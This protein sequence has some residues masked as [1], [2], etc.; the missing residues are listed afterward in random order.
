VATITGTSVSQ[1]AD[2][3]LSEGMD[4]PVPVLQAQD[5]SYVGTVM[6]GS[7]NTNSMIAFDGGG[8]IRWMVPKY[9]P[10]MALDDGGVIA[11]FTADESTDPYGP[12]PLVKFD[13]DGNAVEALEGLTQSW[14][15][16]AYRVGSI[17]Q[18]AELMRLYAYAV[19]YAAVKG[20]SPS[21]SGADVKPY[22]SPQEALLNLSTYNL[23]ARPQCDALLAQFAKMKNIPEATLI[24]QLKAAARNSVDYVFD[25]PSSK[26]P[27]NPVAFHES[28]TPGVTTV[29]DWFNFQNGREGLSQFNGP[30]IFLRLDDWHSWIKGFPIDAPMLLFFSGKPSYYAMG[31]V[32]HET[33]HKQVVGGGFGHPEMDTA[34]ENVAKPNAPPYKLFHNNRS[35]GIG[36]FCFGNLQ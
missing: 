13:K 2:L 5:G 6:D 9:T 12:G 27:L 24:Q 25:G 17:E 16:N 4:A 33:L 36:Q 11:K 21:G 1:M 23:T 29:G 30:A 7:T 10:L 34:I 35:E 26:I 8:N 15:A 3:P 19:T 31:T 18:I 32:M 22:T 20:G 14:E 28:A